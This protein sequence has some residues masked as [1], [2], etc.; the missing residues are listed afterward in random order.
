LAAQDIALHA[1]A[2]YPALAGDNARKAPPPAASATLV[3]GALPGGAIISA[4]FAALTPAAGGNPVTV[5][6]AADGSFR[7]DGLKP[8]PYRFAVMSTPKQPQG[9]SFGEKVQY[10]L[11]QT[12]GALASGAAV[13]EQEP[14]ADPTQAT[15][16]PDSTPAR[17]S[18][19]FTVG[20]Q[21]GRI[22]VDGPP[23]SVEVGADGS[24]SGQL[25]TTT[26]N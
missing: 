18:T 5:P 22:T 13:A 25:S 7:F 11:A 10:G 1:A 4:K 19:N 6:I 14:T 17:I 8:G 23:V 15:R 21:T 12:G 20:K 26:Q 9:Q 3:G 16:L 24:L 2:A